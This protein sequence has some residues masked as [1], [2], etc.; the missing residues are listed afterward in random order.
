M[1]VGSSRLLN[2]QHINKWLQMSTDVLAF[3]FVEHLS[4]AGVVIYYSIYYIVIVKCL[5]FL[6]IG[7]IYLYDN[8]WSE[9]IN[10]GQQLEVNDKCSFRKALTSVELAMSWEDGPTHVG[11]QHLIEV[12]VGCQKGN[13]SASNALNPP[14]HAQ[15]CSSDCWLSACSVISDLDLEQNICLVLFCFFK[16]KWFVTCWVSSIQMLCVRPDVNPNHPGKRLNNNV[17]S[18]RFQDNLIFQNVK[19]LLVLSPLEEPTVVWRELSCNSRSDDLLLDRLKRPT[20]CNWFIVKR[21]WPHWS[22]LSEKLC[23][24]IKKTSPDGIAWLPWAPLSD[25]P[26]CFTAVRV[27]LAFL[28]EKVSYVIFKKSSIFSEFLL[29]YVFSWWFICCYKTKINL[30]GSHSV[31]V[32]FQTWD[33][34]G[35][36]NSVEKPQNLKPRL[37]CCLRHGVIQSFSSKQEWASG[38]SVENMWASN[39]GKNQHGR[40]LKSWALWAFLVLRETGTKHPRLGQVQWT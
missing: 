21:L 28:R 37:Y 22:A 15:S 2:C 23:W 31:L 24:G 4:T 6:S 30:S 12:T 20:I 9:Q 8:I 27:F 13:R 16:K 32:G 36:K 14:R 5:Q 34:Q 7:S 11:K 19:Q 26:R 40:P 18:C 29:N 25:T 17:N 33:F 35:L 39:C 38:V 10:E 1:Y 3:E